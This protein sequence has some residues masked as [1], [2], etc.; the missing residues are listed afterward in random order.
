MTTKDDALRMALEALI[1]SGMWLPVL[2]QAAAL[3]PDECE[4]ELSDFPD[5]RGPQKS[6]VRSAYADVERA[7]A[8]IREAL[9]QPD[10]EDDCEGCP[11][12]ADGGT[13]C[14]ANCLQLES[15]E[16][17]CSECGVTSTDDSMY[18]LYCVDCINKME[19]PQHEPVAW[20]IANTRPTESKPLM[21]V[22]LDEPPSSHLVIP[23]YATP[24]RREWVGLAEEEL[25][26]MCQQTWVYDTVKQWAEIIEARLKEK[27]Q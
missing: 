20:G 1:E 24:P 5:G 15:S 11:C 8:A 6:T 12:G 25:R 27:N 9:E 19:Q 2:T 7:I 23:L 18:A 10:D 3:N 14:G 16:E 4:I 22:M 26:Q 17:G 13:T 21:M